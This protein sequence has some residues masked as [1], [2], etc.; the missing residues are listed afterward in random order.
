M[1]KRQAEKIYKKYARW[2]PVDDFEINGIRS[3][4]V[5]FLSTGNPDWDIELTKK[6]VGFFKKG[7]FVE[8][9]DGGMTARNLIGVRCLSQFD[10]KNDRTLSKL[11]VLLMEVLSENKDTFELKA[12]GHFDFRFYSDTITKAELAAG[13]RSLADKIEA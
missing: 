5:S 10:I 8:A 1:N 13:L 9:K 7:L 4:K 2:F 3:S 6:K 12:S 11:D